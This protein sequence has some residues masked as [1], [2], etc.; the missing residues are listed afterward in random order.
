MIQNR[1]SELQH[2]VQQLLGRC[3]LR[4]QQYERLMKAILANHEISG[5]IDAI[6]TAHA[7]Q[8]AKFSGK[9]LGQLTNALF[10]TYIVHSEA[11]PNHLPANKVPIDRPSITI[12]SSI[13]MPVDHWHETKTAIEE[14]VALRNDLVHHLIERF[15]VWT[16]DGCVK[17][18]NHLEYC[19]KRINVH[20]DE[21]SDWAQRMNDARAISASFAQSE[22]FYDV[23]V[24][25]IA[26][27]GTFDWPDTG[28]V[29]ALREA[30]DKLSISGWTELAA[31]RTWLAEHHADQTPQKY[32]CRTWP[33]VLHES[34]CFRLAY[35]ANENCQKIAWFQPRNE[36]NRTG[37]TS[38]RQIT[39]T[40]A[41]TSD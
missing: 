28:I 17:A 16:E 20:C 37:R 26:P 25:G 33:Q 41:S 9:S 38:Q 12:R 40:P 1:V 7:R 39:H 35:K 21:L 13:E 30:S 19:Y 8:A 4:F 15:D 5:S 34:K 31:A 29:R 3:M 14:L 2:N 6:D 11:E 36:L 10:Q 27:D 22:V 23:I 18:E 32:G 24:N